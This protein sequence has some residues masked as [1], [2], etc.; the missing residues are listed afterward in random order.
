MATSYR[1]IDT[2]PQMIFT[3]DR[4]DAIRLIE[5]GEWSCSLCP[6]MFGLETGVYGFLM[7]DGKSDMSKEDAEKFLLDVEKSGKHIFS[8]DSFSFD[9][10]SDKLVGIP[11]PNQ[12]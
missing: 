5:T 10:L 9:S 2:N 11:L 7:E 1:Y 6:Q 8:N 4:L 12:I 3:D